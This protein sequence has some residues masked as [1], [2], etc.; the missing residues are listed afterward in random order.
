MPLG[1]V[2]GFPVSRPHAAMRS[3]AVATAAV[4]VLLSLLA[5]NS[6]CVSSHEGGGD[7]VPLKVFDSR[8][9]Q[10]VPEWVVESTLQ[11][12]KWGGFDPAEVHTV[13]TTVRLVMAGSPDNNTYR[14]DA[15]TDWSV[16]W[17]AP[18]AAL[19]GGATLEGHRIF[20]V[21]YEISDDEYY[22][23]RYHFNLMP[24][25]GDLGP[26]DF[27]YT[28]ALVPWSTIRTNPAV[29]EVLS[30][31]EDKDNFRPYEA[32]RGTPQGAGVPALYRYF[33]ERYKAIVQANPDLRIKPSV[34]ATVAWLEQA[35]AGKVARSPWASPTTV[36]RLPKSAQHRF[37]GPVPPSTMPGAWP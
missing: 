18:F 28:Y 37:P 34:Q 11:S 1:N 35:A 4:A 13:E 27:G 5:L 9:G 14:V 23:A 26:F 24:N 17:A 15:F 29:I 31:L 16:I 12:D 8:T 25:K 33:V 10:C 19:Y 32:L 22:S 3:G 21:G 7:Y 36:Y 2:P 30:M 6:G 20:A